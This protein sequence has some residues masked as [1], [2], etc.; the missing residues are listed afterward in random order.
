LTTELVQR[1]KDNV[2]KRARCKAGS[3]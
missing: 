2:Q 1:R 3:L